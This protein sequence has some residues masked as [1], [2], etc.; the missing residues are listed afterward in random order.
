MLK[1]RDS[2]GLAAPTPTARAFMYV[3]MYM[4]SNA[5][6][7]RNHVLLPCPLSCQCIFVSLP[8][9]VDYGL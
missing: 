7:L 6:Q 5:T 8:L 4:F 1:S 2:G 9:S 3:C